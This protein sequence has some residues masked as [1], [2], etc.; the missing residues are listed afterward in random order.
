MV[1]NMAKVPNEG[2][3]SAA[4]AGPQPGDLVMVQWGLDEVIGEVVE[5][6]GPPGRPSAYV[7]IPLDE[8]ATETLSVPYGS[9][10]ALRNV[11]HVVPSVDGGWA[12]QSP[13]SKRA[14]ATS[15]T[16]DAAIRRAREIVR[17]RGGGEVVIHGRDGR[18]RDSNTV[19]A[20]HDPHPPRHTAKGDFYSRR[21]EAG[22]P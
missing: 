7:K 3:R 17:N 2:S 12:V 5:I 6:Y 14:S 10:R 1:T 4:P 11:R 15:R 8:D 19:A 18:I 9:L 20:G 21:S 13:T 22:G 16:Q